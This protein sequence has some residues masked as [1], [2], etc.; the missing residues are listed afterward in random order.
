MVENKNN[1]LINDDYFNV[2]MM[3]IFD[4]ILLFDFIIRELDLN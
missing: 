4:V 1:L 2:V 3:Y